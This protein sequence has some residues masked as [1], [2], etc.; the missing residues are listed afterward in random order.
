MSRPNIA[1]IGLPL[2]PLLLVLAACQPQSSAV[3]SAVATT[4][5][6]EADLV[7]RGEYLVRVGGCNDCHTPGYAESG[8]LTPTSEWLQGSPLGHYG[9]W[10]TAYP[11]NLRLT[12]DKLSEQDWL[13]YSATLRTRPLMPDF[14]LRNMS[15]AD[16]RA[17]Y[18]FIR[19][20]GP[21]GVPAPQALPP[22]QLPPPPYLALVLPEPPAGAAAQAP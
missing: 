16:R 13:T 12:I 15:E 17:I 10:G 18:R 1:P 5:D 4:P 3:P 7:A 9:P 22:G 8:G 19:S 6:A 21:A 14:T 11:T 20:L 2:A